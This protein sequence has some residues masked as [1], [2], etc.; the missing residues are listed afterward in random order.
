SRRR[1]TRSK[2]DWSSDVCS[3]DLVWD[4][5]QRR[6]MLTFTFVG[7]GFA[8]IE[9]LGEIEDMARA[10]T[11]NFDSIRRE[12]LRFVLVEAT[13]KI[14]PEVGEELGRYALEQLR[15]RDIEVKLNT[16]L[17]SVVGGLIETSDGDK[18]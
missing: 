18:F 10:E 11:K 4:K 14:L 8:G 9:A 17:E 2:R 7:G 1:H 6:R 5:E 16:K 13:G 3:S 12:D 15:A